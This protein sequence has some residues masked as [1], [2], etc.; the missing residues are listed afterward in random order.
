M[1]RSTFYYHLRQMKQPEKYADIRNH[2]SR[3]FALHKERYGYR[4]ITL[5]LR[6][7]GITINHKTVLKIMQQEGLKSDLRTKKYRTYKGNIYKTEPNLLDRNF[8]TNKPNTKWVTDITEFNIAGKKRFM[9]SIMDLYNREIISYTV[10]HSPTVALVTDMLKKAFVKLKKKNDLLIHSDQ[11]FHFKHY[12]YQKL[13]KGK[14]INQSMSRKGNCYDNAVIENF[15]GILK[16]EL[17]TSSQ[18]F[19]SIEDFDRKLKEYIYY[20]NNER[21]KESLNGM[22]PVQ[23]RAHNIN[24]IN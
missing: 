1:T 24:F 9:A 21:I 13:L 4:R 11:G 23:Y 6:N 19:S 18:K 15:F 3:I 5:S 10:A 12:L 17:R 22:S 14:G 8:K 7:E 2:I 20:Y 16:T